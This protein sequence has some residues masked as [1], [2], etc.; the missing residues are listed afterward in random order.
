MVFDG[1]SVTFSPLVESVG[2]IVC[3]SVVLLVVT[4]PSTVA[5]LFAVVWSDI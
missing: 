3:G 5:L 4:T 2:G 1:C